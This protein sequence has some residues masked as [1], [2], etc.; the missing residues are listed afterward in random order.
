MI[1]RFYTKRGQTM[2]SVISGV[3]D[4][5]QEHISMPDGS[6]RLVNFPSFWSYDAR[7]IVASKYFKVIDGEMEWSLAQVIDRVVTQLANWA[8]EYQYFSDPEDISALRAELAHILLYQK[9]CFNSPVWFNVGV[10]GRS[11]QVSACF[12]TAVDDNMESILGHYE[13]EGQIFKGGSGSGVNVSS[14]RPKGAPLSA[15][16]T[17]SGPL[18][19]MKGWDGSANAIKSGGTT[20]RAA[21]MVI[22]DADHADVHEFIGCKVDEEEKAA[23]L[24][25]AGYDGGIDGAARDTVAFQNANHSVLATDEFMQRATD[26]TDSP[27]Y[28]TLRRIAEAAWKCGDPG[29]I[30][31]GPLNEFNTT[32][33]DGRINV[34]NPCSEFHHQPWTSCNLSSINLERIGRMDDEGHRVF[35][36]SYNSA[37]VR[38]FRHIIRVMALAQDICISG[39]DFPSEKITEGTRKYRPIGIGFTNLGGLLIR[40]GLAYN[41]DGG[42]QAAA[43]IAGYMALYTWEQSADMA[44]KMGPYPAY[45]DGDSIK[46]A[47]ERQSL[48]PI[49]DEVPGLRG[50]WQ[51]MV[52]DATFGFRNSYTT[53]IAPVGT[54]SF[55]MDN[56]T[57]GIEPEIALVRTKSLVGGG[58][59]TTTSGAI[60]AYLMKTR[61]KDAAEEIMARITGMGSVAD[62]DDLTDAEKDVFLTALPCT[63]GRS[64]D[65]M[66]HLLMLA[67]V[68]PFLSGGISK[69]VNCPEDYTVQDIM[70]LY[71][72]AWRLGLKSL[73]IYRDNSKVVQPVTSSVVPEGTEEAEVAEVVEVTVGRKRLPATTV[74]RRHKFRVGE[75]E[76]FIHAGEYEDGSLGEIFL[77][78]GHQGSTFD[79][80]MDS[81]ATAVSLYLQRGG[82]VD[83]ICSKMIGRSFEPHGFTD[84]DDIKTAAS[85]VDYVFQWLQMEYGETQR[86]TVVEIE[87]EEPPQSVP[88]GQICSTCGGQMRQTGTCL[89]CEACGDS[90]GGCG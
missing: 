2:D 84:N 12:L 79:G 55:W 57:T 58:S 43:T 20:R 56:Y 15:G 53:N 88:T 27:E 3:D 77:T 80:I 59:I 10:P 54:I 66:A 74:A 23:A 29:L 89:T 64:L 78:V 49:F 87:S 14:L 73:A 90:F 37:W 85:I 86:Q 60:E 72:V 76:G 13:V 26:D 42:R 36:T 33:N 32:I 68:Q 40:E 47:L 22:M 46:D 28:E 19:F 82:P 34:V 18:S 9:A 63:S 52:D 21:K 24:V 45:N 69:T 67:S 62:I 41:S 48:Q 65:P 50:R 16:G 35:E 11:Q 25:A 83:E 70:R 81:F 61:G 71:V 17:S 51:R 6:V 38:E 1:N 8:T 4:W 7:S 44:N 39:G 30:Y 75:M 5:H 31:E